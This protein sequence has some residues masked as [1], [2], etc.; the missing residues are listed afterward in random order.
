MPLHAG[1]TDNPLRSAAGGGYRMA[2]G[3]LIHSQGFADDT[4]VI[5]S[6]WDDACVQHEWVREFFIAHHFRFNSDK[7]YCVSAAGDVD[8]KF[9]PGIGPRDVLATSPMPLSPQLLE[10]HKNIPCRPPS[11]QFQYLGYPF[12]VD[13]A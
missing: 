8:G 6:S 3:T 10:A 13:L 11:T 12:R 9:L 5:A 7:S 2:D 4:L 1:L